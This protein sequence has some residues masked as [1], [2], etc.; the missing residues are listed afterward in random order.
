MLAV[1][2]V[3]IRT[4]LAI[5]VHVEYATDTAY[6]TIAVVEQRDIDICR[7][8]FAHEL[9]FKVYITVVVILDFL[10]T[11]GTL[12]GDTSNSVRA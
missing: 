3:A 10:V 12:E 6:C 11:N 2:L 1:L 9:I 8:L 4:Y 7:L 5:E